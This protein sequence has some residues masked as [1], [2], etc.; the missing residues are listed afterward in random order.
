MN[1]RLPENLKKISLKLFKLCSTEGCIWSAKIYAERDTSGI[2]Q[3]GIAEDV[4]TELT[5]K[6]LNEDYELA[7]KFLNFKTHVVGTV[8]QTRNLCQDM[9]FLTH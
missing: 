7:F 4:C 2:R 6:L 5:N 3:V 1:R 8:R 9:L